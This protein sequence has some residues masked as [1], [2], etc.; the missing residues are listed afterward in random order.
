[1]S[2]NDGRMIESEKEFTSPPERFSKIEGAERLLKTSIQL[3]FDGGDMLSVHALAAG[4]HE[5]LHTLLLKS[6]I[7]E[8]YLRDNPSVRPEKRKELIALM[9]RT[10]NFL[11]HADRDPDHVLEY[12]KKETP[13]WI[14]DA[15]TMY[16][17]LNGSFKFRAF[18]LF[19]AWFLLEYPS[20]LID[21]TTVDKLLA[22][23]NDPPISRAK[24]SEMLKNSGKYPIPGH[25]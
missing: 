13:F 24:Y 19:N 1:M 25:I 22:T 11:K 4:A 12:Y 18:F 16:A 3:F 7:A 6:G 8:S 9:N 15:I 2:L 5:V 20:V 14:H 23:K 21:P 10:Q 17:R